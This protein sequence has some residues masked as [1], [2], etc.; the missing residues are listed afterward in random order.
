MATFCNEGP[1]KG[2]SDSSATSHC[3]G[4]SK[5]VQGFALNSLRGAAIGLCMSVDE[6]REL[7]ESKGEGNAAKL[8]VQIAELKSDNERLRHELLQ[9][10]ESFKALSEFIVVKF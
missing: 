9:S 1:E 2:K 8:R 10:K 6:L 4:D 5:G 7:L 3:C